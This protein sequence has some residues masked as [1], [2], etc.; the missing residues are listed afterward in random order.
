MFRDLDL[1]LFVHRPGLLASQPTHIGFGAENGS[2]SEDPWVQW[3]GDAQA[4]PPGIEQM[5]LSSLLNADYDVLVHDYSATQGFPT[6]EVSVRIVFLPRG[7]EHIII[8]SGG[9]GRWWNVCRIQGSKG[10][11]GEINRVEIECPYS[12][13]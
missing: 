6:G 12:I 9:S 2:L 4:S 7:D 10:R 8:P 1:H 3:S 5:T 13:A 11:I